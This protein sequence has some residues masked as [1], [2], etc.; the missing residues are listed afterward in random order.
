MVGEV[1]DNYFLCFEFGFFTFSM[2]LFG[3]LKE[4]GSVKPQ[5]NHF[6]WMSVRAICDR[7]YYWLFLKSLFTGGLSCTENLPF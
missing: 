7:S 5:K 4:G 2:A 6:R 1:A 3:F